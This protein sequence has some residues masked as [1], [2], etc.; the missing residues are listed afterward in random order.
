MNLKTTLTLLAVLGLLLGGYWLMS[1]TEQEAQR[2]D[3]EA[4]RV[5]PYPPESFERITIHQA[6]G[7][8]VTGVRES[9][10]EWRIVEPRE[11]DAAHRAWNRVAHGL[12]QFTNQRT[13]AETVDE[14]EMY[15]LAEPRITVRATTED[16]DSRAFRFGQMEPTQTMRYV[17]GPDGAVFLT[18]QEFFQEFDRELLDLRDRFLIT[19][20]EDDAVTRVEFARIRPEETGALVFEEEDGDWFIREPFEALAHN[21]MVERMVE[22][23]VYGVGDRFIDDPED[24]ADY[25]LDPPGAQLTVKTE[26]NPEGQTLYLGSFTVGEADEDEE[27]GVYLRRADRD[28]VIVASGALLNSLPEHP[29]QFRQRELVTRSAQDIRRLTYSREDH[30]FVLEQHEDTG[31]TVAE[32]DL[33]DEDQTAISNFI[34]ALMMLEGGRHLDEEA[35]NI[36]FMDPEIEIEIEYADGSQPHPIQLGVARVNEE[37]ERYAVQDSGA[38]FA[39][40]EQATALV[41]LDPFD[42]R[43]G[44]LLPFSISEATA[45]D[46]S[47]E[48]TDYHFAHDGEAWTVEEP[49]DMRLETQGDMMALLE[50]LNET[51]T[52]GMEQSEIPVDL[53]PYGLDLPLMRV[54]VTAG[55]ETVGPLEVGDPAEDNPQHRFALA[56]DRSQLLRISQSLIN[57]VRE[58]L[59][60]VVEDN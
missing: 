46:L 50:A 9:E 33:E 43:R 55:E 14:P 19:A 45:V 29:D 8:P 47:F 56:A 27:G 41:R 51:T 7:V 37:E 15:G 6:G 22:D 38:A 23:I 48:G 18:Q 2:R 10:A 20:D 39:I 52:V 3:Y 32:P 4:R 1:Y 34:R 12:S 21:E 42:F 54:S 26:S 16:G 36:E 60:G 31:W 57:D 13:I 11:I 25:G 53:T 44:E 49:M 17:E 40:S 35:G 58:A 30:H 24:Y 28:N 5:L 59:R